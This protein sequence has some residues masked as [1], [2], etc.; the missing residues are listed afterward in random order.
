MLVQG[1][2]EPVMQMTTR[3]RNR[4]A[5]QADILGA[6]AFG[7]KNGLCIAGDHQS[8]LPRP[9]WT[10]FCTTLRSSPSP[11]GATGSRTGP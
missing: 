8:L 4:I 6:T 10:G 3:D 5:I 7:I 9:F 1:G 2:M 11:A